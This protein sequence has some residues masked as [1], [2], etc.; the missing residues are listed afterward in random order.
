MIHNSFIIAAEVLSLLILVAFLVNKVKALFVS[1]VASITRETDQ[2]EHMQI[3]ANFSI[4]DNEEKRTEK[5][6]AL[7]G[8]GDARRKF[9]HD[10]FQSLISDA[11]AEKAKQ[12]KA[13]N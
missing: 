13:A 3:S 4:F 5:L 1:S 7:F 8:L 11:Q 6:Q 10:R 2:G 12:L 9:C